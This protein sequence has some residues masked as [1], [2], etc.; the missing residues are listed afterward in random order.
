M[1]QI[2]ET[3]LASRIIEEKKEYDL[4]IDASSDPEILKKL[5]I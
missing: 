2:G 4:K 1:T 3:H 5:L